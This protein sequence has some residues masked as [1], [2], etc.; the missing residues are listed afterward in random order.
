MTDILDVG[1]Q[2]PKWVGRK[3]EEEAQRLLHLNRCTRDGCR[4]Q[5]PFDT[6]WCDEHL[7]EL[8]GQ[9]S[10]TPTVHPIA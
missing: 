9:T 3:S 2:R 10:T 8:R 5:L 1:R 4:K 7:A 6:A